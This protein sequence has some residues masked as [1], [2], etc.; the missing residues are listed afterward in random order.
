MK[1]VDEMRAKQ[2]RFRYYIPIASDKELEVHKN[3]FEFV[4][5]FGRRVL[6]RVRK[7]LIVDRRT[8]VHGRKPHGNSNMRKKI[9]HFWT[10]EADHETSHYN[11]T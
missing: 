9:G 3:A 1:I 5:D 8:V 2:K 6:E 10:G 7:N 11:S 4:F